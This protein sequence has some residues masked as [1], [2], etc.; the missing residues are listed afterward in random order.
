MIF[1]NSLNYFGKFFFFFKI[2]LRNI[3]FNSNLY[4]K[5]ISN[6][7]NRDLE[8][9]PNPNTLDCLVKYEKKKNKIDEFS[10]NSI[11]TD[12]KI[13][14]KDYKKLHSFFWLF[15]LDLKSSKNL[16]RNTVEN[17]ITSNS[18]YD[19]KSWEIDILSKRVIA[20]I[21]NSKLTYEDSDQEYK[22]KF[23]TIIQK[24]I[25]HLMNEI[26]HS[27]W[28]D[29]K[30]IGCAAIILGGLSYKDKEGYLDFGLNL[31]KKIIRISFDNTGFPKSRN[32]GQLSFY[33]KY[34]VLIREWLKESQNEIPEYIDET[35]YYLGQSYSLISRG[36]S[37]FFFNG[38][39][40]ID[41]SD[42]DKYLIRLGYNFKNEGHEIGNYAILRNKKISLMMDIGSNPEKKFSKDYQAGSLSFEII[43]GDNKLI[44]NSGYFKN[45][46]HKLNL[47]SKTTAAHNTLIVNNKSSCVFER[48]NY[49]ESLIKK[50]LKITNKIIIKQKN[51]WSVKATHDGYNKEFGITHDRQIEFFTEQNKFI[52]TDTLIKKKNFKD[53]NFEVRFHLDPKA[54]IMKTQDGKSIFIDIENE[55]WKFICVGHEIY[56]DN[57]LFFGKKN[58]Y[59]ENQNICISGMT[60]SENQTIKW[61]ITKL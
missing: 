11:W 1:K 8:Y 59:I 25:N 47:I 56:I 55:G 44:T 9:K 5:K 39:Y 29:D 61:E 15:S 10:L 12:K 18:N 60:K 7:S 16:T 20:W 49:K 22:K 58:S 31:L 42:F 43:T 28:V 57:G 14:I 30:M 38:N 37:G 32:I 26:Q 53:S 40:Q 4:N 27:E 34:F 35:I 51:Y 48:G 41:N 3:Y 46:H 6:V 45:Y 36:G 24:Q 50:G 17:W 21:S 13:K 54:K 2:N 52:G 19:T 33:L 23:N